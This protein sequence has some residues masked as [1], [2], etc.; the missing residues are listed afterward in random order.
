MYDLSKCEEYR[1]STSRYGSF[2]P[3]PLDSG[4]VVATTY[5]R[6]GYLPVTQSLSDAVKVEYAPHP[7]K[8]LLPE[9]R[10]WGV[11]NLDTVRFDCATADS[12][13]TQTP[14]KR[15][16]R[17]AHA[18]NIH[19]WAPASYDPYA[20]V[21]ESHIA[22]NLG[23]TIM[24]QNILST[25]EGF[26]TWGWNKSEGSVFKGTLRYNGLGVNLW[27]SGTYGGTQQIYRVAIYNPESGKLEYPDEPEL[28]RYYSVS[29][30]ATLP[31][32]I[33]RGYHTSQFAVGASWNFSNGMVANVDNL[34]I[35]GGKVTN[36]H[37]IGY[38]QGVHLLNIGVSFQDYVRLSHRDFLPPWG[39]VLSANSGLNPASTNFGQLFVLYGKLYTPGFAPHHS[40]SLA[41]SY[42]NSFGGFQ[43]DMVLSNLAFKSSRLIPRGYTSYDIANNDYVATSLNYQLPVWYPDGGIRGVIYFK[44][45]RVNVGAD[46]ASFQQRYVDK[47]DGSLMHY[48]KHLGSFG[49]D[50][51]VDFNP[52]VMP[53]AAT[54]SVTFSL[55]RKMELVPFKD[56]KFY[57]GFSMGLPF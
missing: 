22:F 10:P 32:L 13:V 39:I 46:Y 15:F 49:L 11:V 54:I 24:T 35:G 20:L 7:P 3:M 36:F 33:H 26:A 19:S 43:S 55:Y 42:Q 47:T 57:F 48:R 14:P 8:I 40:L 34:E 9:T 27:V 38:S 53:D 51:G 18:F 28:G 4:R 5:D 56:G 50:L 16:S 17:F 29:A 31:I 2:Q 37:T 52:F 23:A 21:E 45:L 12:V 41:A 1:L 6:R 25:V 44:R 30:G